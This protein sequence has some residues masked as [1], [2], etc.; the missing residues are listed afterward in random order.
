MEMDESQSSG[1][2]FRWNGPF[3]FQQLLTSEALKA[4]FSRPGVY[5]WV[6]PREN[7]ET[8]SYVGRATGTPNLWTRQ[9]D[10]YS[11]FIGGR[12]RIPREYRRNE[13]A[14]ELDFNR[15]SVIETLFNLPKYQEVVEDGFAYA[16]R[17]RIFL[18]PLDAAVVRDAERNLL[19]DLCP[20]ETKWGTL[21]R[22]A[23]RLHIIHTGASWASA[24][25]RRRIRDYVEFESS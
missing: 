10:H 21:S 18:C 22:P 14:W 23:N 6:E 3:T 1:V 2:F 12:Y 4:E 16:Q 7:G 25:V 8:I 19:Y 13:Q 15:P 20:T 5:L 11:N 24:E 9:A 17:I